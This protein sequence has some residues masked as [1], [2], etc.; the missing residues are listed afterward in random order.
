MV[1]KPHTVS[2]T[3]DTFKRIKDIKKQKK[4]SWEQCFLILEKTLKEFTL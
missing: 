3:E 1:T 2:I 4:L